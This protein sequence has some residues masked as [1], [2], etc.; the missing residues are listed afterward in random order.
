VKYGDPAAFKFAEVATFPYWYAPT[1]KTL[2]IDGPEGSTAAQAQYLADAKAQ[3]LQFVGIK[4]QCT[5]LIRPELTIGDIA[6]LN[7]GGIN[8]VTGVVTETKHQLGPQGFV[9]TFITDSGGVIL[10]DDGTNLAVA[11]TASV[12][13]ANR[14]RRMT[15]FIA[16]PTAGRKGAGDTGAQGTS[17]PAGLPGGTGATGAAGT[18]GAAGINGTD[19]A[20]GADGA[21]GAAGIGVPAGGTIGQVLT[22]RSGTDFDAEWV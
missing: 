2:Y 12:W 19:G 4:E 7:E 13:G 17:G 22:K 20:P 18:D 10:A 11:I 21:T 5:G 3:E 6:Q 15:D 16:K 8:T 14:Q 9:T 1:H